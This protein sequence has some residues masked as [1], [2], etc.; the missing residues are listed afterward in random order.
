MGLLKSIAPGMAGTR[1]ANVGND[2]SPPV[3]TPPFSDPEKV[4][5]D[6]KTYTEAYESRKAHH[7]EIRE[8]E[9]NESLKQIAE[10]TRKTDH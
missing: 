5:A 7:D 1:D 10:N 8:N 9:N 6:R 2:P 4:A 3:D